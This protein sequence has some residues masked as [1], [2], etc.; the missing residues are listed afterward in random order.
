M[1]RVG[2]RLRLCVLERGLVWLRF[3]GVVLVTTEG[4]GWMDGWVSI[5][6]LARWVG[7]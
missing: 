5:R 1:K 6:R 7:R 3:G 4:D 2:C